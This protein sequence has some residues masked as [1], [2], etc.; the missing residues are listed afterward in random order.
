MFAPTTYNNKLI[1]WVY[2]VAKLTQP[3]QVLWLDGSDAEYQRLIKTLTAAGTLQPLNQRLRP[4]SYLARSDPKDVARVESRT[5]ICSKEEKDAGPT[6][7]WHDP[8]EMREILRDRFEGSMR[9]RTMYVVPFSMGPVGGPISQVGVELTDSAYVALSMHVMTRVG[10][11]ALDVLGND[12][13]FV[14]AVHSVGYPLRDIWTDRRPDIPWPCNED[15]YIVHFPETREIWSY[16]SGYGG[17]ALLGKKCYALRIAS[18]QARDNGWMAEHMM[19]LKVTPPPVKGI[20]SPDGLLTEW[21][22]PEPIYVAGAFP[23]ACGKTNLAMI[24]TPADLPGWK[25]ET[26]GDDIAWMKPGA[27]GQLYGINPEF[28]FF[29]VAPGTN[30]KTN[31]NAMRAMEKDTI[32]TN[33]ALTDDGDVWWEG[34]DG[35]HPAHLVDWQG[36]DIYWRAAKKSYV[37]MDADITPVKAAHP[38]SRFTS[39]TRNAPSLAQEYSNAPEGVPISAILFGGR[40]PSLVPLVTESKS[41][42]HGVY[43]G[44]TI[45]SEQTA[46]AEGTVGELRRDPMAMK[47][48]IGYNVADYWQHWLDMETI[49]GES[50]LPVIYRVNW[51]R[52]EDGEFLWP[53]FTQNA[54]V[55]KWVYERVTGKTHALVTPLGLT[56]LPAQI[57]QADERLFK[58]DVQGWFKE[59]ELSG[60]YLRKMNAPKALQRV[61]TDDDAS[62][63]ALALHED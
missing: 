21:T 62:L 55:L 61:L 3:D 38:N 8:D 51:F 52:Q 60:E 48:F 7:N 54:H 34:I 5:F 63:V 27:D 23:S 31:P 13:E 28:G 12:G 50:N 30:Y 47:P 53:G 40:R 41:W 6:N 10:Q 18:V 39:P 56:P 9:G 29:G 44:A 26:I 4:N 32:F 35:P 33:V 24:E 59:H 57:P 14:P 22:Q 11:G 19:I 1:T 49:I 45:A 20:D 46:A 25:F 36:R 37:L 15:K 16:G 2:N 43:M 42:A 58:V 17:N